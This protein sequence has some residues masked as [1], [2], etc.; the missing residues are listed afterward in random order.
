MDDDKELKSFHQIINS[1][2]H[3]KIKIIPIAIS[4]PIYEYTDE[5]MEI[6]DLTTES[7]VIQ[8]NINNKTEENKIDNN[9]N[10]K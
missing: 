4:K 7:V 8:E 1:I 3:I 10:G 6:L 2:E 9:G 5:E